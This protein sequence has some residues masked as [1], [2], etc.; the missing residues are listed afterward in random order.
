MSPSRW[1]KS[2][3]QGLGAGGSIAKKIEPEGAPKTGVYEKEKGTD[4][5]QEGSGL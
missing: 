5:D 3:Y 4:C 2:M 1:G